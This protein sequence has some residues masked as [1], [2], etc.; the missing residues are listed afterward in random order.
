MNADIR[1]VEGEKGNFT[2]TVAHRP[3]Y[4]D[5]EKCTGC[6]LCAEHCPIEAIDA[7]NMGMSVGPAV[8]VDYQQAVP[9]IF[10]IDKDVCLGCGLCFELCQANARQEHFGLE[11][12]I[13]AAPRRWRQGAPLIASNASTI[14]FYFSIGFLLKSLG[15][16]P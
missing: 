7:Y 3:R 11:G 13:S 16:C 5:A 10:T 12:V 1:K 6:G 14:Q 2:V 4:V 15:S 9:K 8:S